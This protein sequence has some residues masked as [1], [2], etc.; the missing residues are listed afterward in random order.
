MNIYTLPEETVYADIESTSFGDDVQGEAVII[1]LVVPA[2]HVDE[3]LAN[4]NEESSTSP[5]VAYARPLARAAMKALK[6]WKSRQ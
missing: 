4:W 1:R 3:L 5:L 2:E 6:L